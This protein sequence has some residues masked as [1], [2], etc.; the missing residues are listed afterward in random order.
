MKK[1]I[2]PTKQEDSVD[3]SEISDDFEGLIIGY[4]NGIIN[5]LALYDNNARVWLYIQQI[6]IG[7]TIY[8]EDSIFGLINSVRSRNP[9]IEFFIE[10]H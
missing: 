10:Q 9:K 1:L 4:I 2:I 8:E 3:I 6:N 7:E 5:G